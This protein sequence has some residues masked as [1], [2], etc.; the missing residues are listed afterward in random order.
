MYIDK[1]NEDSCVSAYTHLTYPG[2]DPKFNIRGS[3]QRVECP[4]LLP[5]KLKNVGMGLG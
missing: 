3:S 4:G 1:E 2:V 5:K